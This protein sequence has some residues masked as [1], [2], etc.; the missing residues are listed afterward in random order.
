MIDLRPYRD[1]DLDAVLK[2][3]WD[4]WHSIRPGLTHPQ[5]FADWRR[6]W[7]REIAPAQAVIVAA[8]DGTV[9]GCAAADLAARELTQIFVAPER[10]R[11]GIG[12]RLL[13]WA[14]ARMPEGFSLHTLAKNCASRA[15][16]RRHG[17]V[18]GHTRSNPINGM[19]QIEY[20][21]TPPLA[22]KPPERAATTA[23][24]DVRP[25]NAGRSA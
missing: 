4:A 14:Q 24:A 16:Y 7:V 2:I 12:Q 20:S 13:T 10:N 9:V 19:P 22:N 1:D 18:E 25:S 5:P 6:R 21:W 11:Q 15:F 23:P 17:L 3:W 8:D